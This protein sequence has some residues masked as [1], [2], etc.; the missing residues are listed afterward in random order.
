[1]ENKTIIIEIHKI[2]NPLY[3][4]SKPMLHYNNPFELLIAVILSAQCTDAMVNRITPTLFSLWPT[5]ES[6]MNAVI[7]DVEECI[8]AAGF[9]HT[10]A[11]NIIK[12]AY[13]LYSQYNNTMPKTMNEMLKFPG[14]GRKTANVVLSAIYDI[15]SIIVDTHVIRV[16]NRLGIVTSKIP[17][18]IESELQILLPTN[19]WTSF[20]HEINRHGRDTCK[21]RNPNCALCCVNK[22]CNW[23]SFNT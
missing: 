8:H 19:I 5:A 15:P 13:I 23:V 17:V 21:S 10:K 14:V 1:M 20:S 4:N 6:L 7:A 18:K 22:Y 12:T 2:L 3:T 11:K 16:T 9:F